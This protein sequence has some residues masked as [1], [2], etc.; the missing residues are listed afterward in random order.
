MF[1]IIPKKAHTFRVAF[2]PLEDVS[3]GRG[4]DFSEDEIGKSQ[5]DQSEII[6]IEFGLNGDQAQDRRPLDARDAVFSIGKIPGV[7]EGD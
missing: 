2:D 5:N 4:N 3:E 1:H 7:G 6:E